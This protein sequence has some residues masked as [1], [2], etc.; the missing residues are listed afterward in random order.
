[1]Q[2]DLEKVLLEKGNEEKYFLL[3]RSLA[4]EERQQMLQFLK[5]NIDVFAWQ[6]YDMP[7]IHSKVMCHKLHIDPTVKPIK[8]K[9][10]RALP[11]KAKAVEEEV[12]KLL[13]AGAVREA[14]FPERISNLVVVRKHNGKWRVCVD[15]NDLNRACPK[16][17]FPLPRINQLVDSA[18]GHERMSFL[19]AYSGYH[20]IPLFSPDQENTAFITS[21]SL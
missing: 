8:Q 6:S 11:E 2:E 15:F 21:L 13:K 5:E 16:D 14:K 4:A 9:P 19:D 20:Q 18:A 10:H 1:M 7:G 17:S 12:H 3:G